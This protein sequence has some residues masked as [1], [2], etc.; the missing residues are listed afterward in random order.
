MD[1]ED[2]RLR[3]LLAGM[4]EDERLFE[5]FFD[6]TKGRV[7]AFL[8]ARRIRPSDV[9]DVTME[10]FLAVYE[11]C[12][13]FRG[14]AKVLTWVFGIVR[15]KCLEYY[16]QNRVVCAPLVEV[17]D[18]TDFER[19]AAL[20][21]DLRAA[22]DGLKPEEYDVLVLRVVWGM[23]Y[24]GMEKTLARPVGTL[25]RICHETRCKLRSGLGA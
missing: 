11:G 14:E 6:R 25:K 24:A 12:G 18:S 7:R 5:E 17:A 1:G 23:K 22:I 19:C 4:R 21:M 13:R 8:L 9:E 2:G 16:R 3:E 15:R 10:C 20:A